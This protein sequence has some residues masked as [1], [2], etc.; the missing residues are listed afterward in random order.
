MSAACGSQVI[1]EGC[2]FDEPRR[3]QRGVGVACALLLRHDVAVVSQRDHRTLGLLRARL[4]PGFE[5]DPGALDHHET[6]WVREHLG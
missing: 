5:P 4:E 1:S 3:Y 2:R 6:R